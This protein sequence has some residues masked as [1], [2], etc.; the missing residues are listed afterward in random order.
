MHQLVVTCKKL[1]DNSEGPIPLKYTA[2]S[3]TCKSPQAGGYLSEP[4]RVHKARAARPEWKDPD[5]ERT[6]NIISGLSTNHQVFH[7]KPQTLE[8]A[9]QQTGLSYLGRGGFHQGQCPAEGLLCVTAAEVGQS[10]VAVLHQ[11]AQFLPQPGFINLALLLLQPQNIPEVQAAPPHRCSSERW[12]HSS[13]TR[14]NGWGIWSW[15]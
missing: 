12:R 3:R 4:M 10:R 1:A 2:K 13:S 9:S 14:V 11:A 5:P 8:S 15:T 6:Q 7:I